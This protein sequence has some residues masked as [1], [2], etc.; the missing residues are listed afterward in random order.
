MKYLCFIQHFDVHIQR[1]VQFA[2]GSHYLA[3]ADLIV[4]QSHIR[5]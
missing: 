2:I 1:V 5:Y 3:L 4:L